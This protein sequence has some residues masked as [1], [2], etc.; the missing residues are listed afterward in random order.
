MCVCVCGVSYAFDMSKHVGRCLCLM[1][2]LGPHCQSYCHWPWIRKTQ[3]LVARS[4]V[5]QFPEALL[6]GEMELKLAAAIQ[7]T[8]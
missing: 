1:I 5:D 6:R 2:T 4:R 3:A 7:N 8:P